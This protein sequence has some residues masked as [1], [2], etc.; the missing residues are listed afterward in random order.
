VTGG[1]DPVHPT[2]AAQLI[3]RLLP[4]ARYHDPVVTAAEWDAHFNA[5]PYPEVS[6]LQ[7]ARIAPVWR[8][9]IAE[10]EAVEPGRRV[11]G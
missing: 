3:H 1:C 10:V 11:T 2:E 7:G 5:R 9:F 8:R 4:G 6:N